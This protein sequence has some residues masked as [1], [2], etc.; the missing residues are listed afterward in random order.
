MSLLDLCEILQGAMKDATV[1]VK[2]GY[3]FVKAD[4]ETYRISIDKL[5]NN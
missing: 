5:E 3:L 2:N 4:G 1:I